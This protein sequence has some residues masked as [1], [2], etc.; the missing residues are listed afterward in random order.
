MKMNKGRAGAGARGLVRNS[1]F[2]TST[3]EH[4]NTEFYAIAHTEPHAMSAKLVI[5]LSISI[6]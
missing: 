4:K 1:D 6:T 2:L 5:V 3:A